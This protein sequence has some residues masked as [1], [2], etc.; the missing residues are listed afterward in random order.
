VT[1]GAPRRDAEPGLRPHRLFLIAHEDESDDASVSH[2]RNA[3]SMAGTSRVTMLS[4]CGHDWL[5]TRQ[6]EQPNGTSD[7]VSYG[8]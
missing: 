3:P 6:L 2:C 5:E 7:F 8:R 4:V 1:S